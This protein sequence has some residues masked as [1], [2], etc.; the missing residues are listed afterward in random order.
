MIN[1]KHVIAESILKN[2]GELEIWRIEVKWAHFHQVALDLATGE[3]AD[4]VKEIRRA[5]KIV[6]SEVKMIRKSEHHK[7]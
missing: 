7:Y 5:Q 2:I 6:G 3:F 1:V 4:F